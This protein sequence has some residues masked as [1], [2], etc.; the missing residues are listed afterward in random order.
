ME[1]APSTARLALKWG[2]IAGVV[3]IVYSTILY[4][5]GLFS[6]Q[7]ASAFSMVLMILFIVL[8]M[9]DFRTLNGGYMSYGE[10]VSLGSLM[11]AISGLFS[12]TFNYIYTTFIDPTIQQQ[13]I[14][15]MREQWEGQGMSDEQIE[16]MIEATQAFQSPGLTF[17]FG[18]LGAILIGL[19]ISLIVAAFMRR[20]K[21]FGDFQ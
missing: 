8:A 16:G 15:K 20:N 11:S 12:S 4:L 5:T 9:R 2:V 3:Y 13:V 19:I 1:E 17:V 10:G 14:D 7:L 21:P 18:V 6:N